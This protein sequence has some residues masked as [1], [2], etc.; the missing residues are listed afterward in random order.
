MCD[1]YYKLK[2]IYIVKR[3]NKHIPYVWFVTIEGPKGAVYMC[4]I[5]NFEMLLRYQ[6]IQ[7]K[8]LTDKVLMAYA[9]RAH[10]ERYVSTFDTEGANLKIV[11]KN[12]GVAPENTLIRPTNSKFHQLKSRF[13]FDK[14]LVKDMIL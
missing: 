11:A 6:G 12:I 2:E 3:D 8:Y 9:H 7:L 5:F 4:D 13:Y 10:I 1:H 14:S